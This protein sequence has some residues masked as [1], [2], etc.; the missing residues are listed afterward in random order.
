MT[1]FHEVLPLLV[2]PGDLNSIILTGY[3]PLKQ[4]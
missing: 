2:C 3:Y 1:G 4:A